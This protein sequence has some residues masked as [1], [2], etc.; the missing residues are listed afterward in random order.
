MANACRITDWM[1]NRTEFPMQENTIFLASDS[2]S[3][4]MQ[5]GLVNDSYFGRFQLPH[6]GWYHQGTRTFM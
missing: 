5:T 4:S 6:Q 1:L 3:Y 2:D